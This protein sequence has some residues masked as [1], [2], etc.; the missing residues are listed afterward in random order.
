MPELVRFLFVVSLLSSCLL[1]S[2]VGESATLAG[3]AVRPGG[4]LDIRF[5]VAKDCQDYAAAGGNPRP[6]TGRAVLAF[7]KNFDPARSWP[8]LIVTST[9]DANRTSPMDAPRSEEH[10]SELQSPVH[11]VCRLLLE[12]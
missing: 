1:C 3:Q 10:T 7:P 8:I 9:S 5:P 6:N 11:L 2:T 12:K 4:T